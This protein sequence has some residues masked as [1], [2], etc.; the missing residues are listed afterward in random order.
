MK[1]SPLSVVGGFFLRTL[2][3]LIPLLALWY[4][5]GAWIIEPPVWLARQAMIHFFPDWVLGVRLEDGQAYLL[6]TFRMRAPDG[7]VA[8]LRNVVEVLRYAY[9]LPL[10]LALLLGSRA[11]GIWWKFPLAALVMV[12]FQTWG[13]CF[14]WLSNIAINVGAQTH[15]VTGF[16]F[17]TRTLIALGKQLG[18]LILPTLVPVLFWLLWEQKFV[19]TVVMDGALTGL[20]GR[21]NG[22]VAR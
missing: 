19:R 16:G 5:A 17:W 3:W 14:E 1:S 22:S 11:Q 21:E 4:W 15:A 8:E 20:L 12:F 2:L 10:L 7:R 13:V 18:A 6:T 9:G